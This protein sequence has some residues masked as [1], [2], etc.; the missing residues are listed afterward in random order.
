M[1]DY[2]KNLIVTRFPESMYAKVLNDPEYFRELEKADQV[3]RQYYE[4]TYALYQSGNFADVV[5]RTNYAREN[6]T[7]HK[8]MPQFNYLGVLADGKTADRSIFR[9]SLKAI[10]AKYPGTEIASDANN[11]ISYMDKEHPEI[12]E[13]E[14]IKISQEL[15]LYSPHGK[16]YFVFALDKRINTN[17]FVF[18]VINYNLDYHDSLDLIVEI[19][20][21]NKAQNLITVRIFSDQEQAMQYLT[22][23]TASEEILKD[24]PE[25]N[26][27]PFVITEKDL[28]TLRKDQSVERYLK[29]YNENYR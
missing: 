11:L 21:L 23:V 8:L 15:Y 22:G 25:I 19:I 3:V 29:F 6:Y 16:H 14:E 2:Y 12:K 13:A 18:N 27:I 7:S 4:Q 9:D 10:A 1:V 28:G 20:D 5:T 17:Q 24:M 26:K